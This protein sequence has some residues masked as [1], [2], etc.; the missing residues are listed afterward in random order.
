MTGQQ[1]KALAFTR[2]KR[3]HQTSPSTRLKVDRKRAR[4]RKRT[5]ER[6]F[7]LK[8]KGSQ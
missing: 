5:I 4:L 8:Q 1:I 3:K 6:H 2:E 7:V